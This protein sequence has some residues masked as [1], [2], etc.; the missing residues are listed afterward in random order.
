MKNLENVKKM[1]LQCV[2]INWDGT[3]VSSAA[4]IHQ[5]YLKTMQAAAYPKYLLFR[6]RLQ[7]LF[8]WGR[9]ILQIRKL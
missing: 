3:L 1:M 4:M 2:V 6:I 9:M 8:L 7:I 5:A